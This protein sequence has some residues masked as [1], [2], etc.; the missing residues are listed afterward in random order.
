MWEK[1]I[2]FFGGKQVMRNKINNNR[3]TSGKIEVRELLKKNRKYETRRRCAPNAEEE[4][5]LLLGLKTGSGVEFEENDVSVLNNVRL[6]L[7]TILS[8]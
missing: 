5:L 6:S 3:N 2:N 7:L 4:G 1:N 8:S